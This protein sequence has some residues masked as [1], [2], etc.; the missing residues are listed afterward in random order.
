MQTK[1]TTLQ[2]KIFFKQ[3][4]EKQANAHG[5]K[6]VSLLIVHEQEMLLFKG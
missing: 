5:Y 1:K 4:I 6:L 2:E 3:P